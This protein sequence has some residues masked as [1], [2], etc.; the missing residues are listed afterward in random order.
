MF[1]LLN[2]SIRAKLTFAMAFITVLLIVVYLAF[3]SLTKDLN[4]GVEDFSGKYLPSISAIL[5]ADRDLYQAYVA[6]LKYQNTKA[7]K[8]LA[9]F[10]ENAQ[11]AFE[12]MKQYQS[13]M[14]DYSEVQSK[15][16][17]F[18]QR[19]ND[20]K[21]ESDKFFNLA[22][23]GQ[24]EQAAKLLSGSVS[25]KFSALRDL[26][27]VAGEFLDKHAQATSKALHKET[28]QYQFWLLIL[29]ALAVVVG[30]LISVFV[31]KAV[32]TSIH[33]LT[34]RIQE[35]NS[36]DGDLT[37]RINSK[38]KDECGTLANSFDDFVNSLQSLIKEIS[39]GSRALDNSSGELKSSYEESQRLNSQQ[40]HNLDMVATAVTEFSSS[41]K[42]VAQ[43]TSNTSDVA[44]DTVAIITRGVGVINESVNHIQALSDSIENANQSIETLA[45]DSENIASV[46]DV[47]RNIAEQTNL[48]AL[49]AAIEA[50]R[51]GEQGR[52][53]AVVADEVRSLASKTQQSTE[54][55]QQMID[56]LQSGVRNA[57]GSIKD[58][59][60]K[61]QMNVDLTNQTQQIFEEIQGS[62][63]QVNDMA[64]QIAAATEQQSST[65]EEINSNL[66]EL[67]DN[68]RDSQA[69]SEK[70]YQITQ[71]V[72]V[73]TNKLSSDVQQF[74][75]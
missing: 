11:Q 14:K 40:S 5:N 10:Q 34:Q 16:N 53:F 4:N 28:G 70:I 56:K 72:D 25:N 1:D 6:Q 66:L 29:V 51:A 48:L 42:E 35:I 58:G 67:N 41:V 3:N 15:L 75:V 73:S 61:V 2:T 39:D 17:A 54:E 36:G 37:Q 27:D 46:L 74:K 60:E 50:A 7:P 38:S 18:E 52:G 59:S 21:S 55:I 43:N 47:I 30:G 45:V 26:Y 13:L 65:S 23:Q 20:W 57:V 9:S 62:T 63:E 19:F 22:L 33:Q 68:N 49:N 31:P 24:D 69:L 71:D 12:R 8:D 44:N 64:T 32:V